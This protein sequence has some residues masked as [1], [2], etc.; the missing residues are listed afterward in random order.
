MKYTLIASLLIAG[1][2]VRETIEE[3]RVLKSLDEQGF[4]NIDLYD[5]ETCSNFG[6]EFIADKDGKVVIGEICCDDQLCVTTLYACEL[7][8]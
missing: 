4:T 6:N 7:C 8:N 5:A 3:A 2:N 1:C